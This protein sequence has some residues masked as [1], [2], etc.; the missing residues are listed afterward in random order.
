MRPFYSVQEK[1]PARRIA[2][3]FTYVERIG[4]TKAQKRLWSVGTTENEEPDSF[5][6]LPPQTGFYTKR[7]A[8]FHFDP[9]LVDYVAVREAQLCLREDNLMLY[10]M[11]VA[12]MSNAFRDLRT[13]RSAGFRI[14]VMTAGHYVGFGDDEET[15]LDRK[16]KTQIRQIVNIHE[17]PSALFTEA[18]NWAIRRNLWHLN[19]T[20]PPLLKTNED[21]R[22]FFNMVGTIS[23][24]KP[25][26]WGQA[27]PL[28]HKVDLGTALPDHRE[29]LHWIYCVDPENGLLAFHNAIA[30]NL[31]SLDMACPIVHHMK[32]HHCFRPDPLPASPLPCPRRSTERQPR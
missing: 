9:A 13:L 4:K 26:L 24:T 18:H 1:D 25:L 10:D 30:A 2:C 28:G 5:A 3:G 16:L 27:P 14:V 6:D 19:E 7:G 11:D 15:L 32:G 20:I 21:E 12:K 29:R 23:A 22:A 8:P 31:G 17:K